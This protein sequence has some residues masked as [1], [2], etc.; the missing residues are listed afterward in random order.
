MRA[1]G[2]RRR[3]SGEGVPTPTRGP[4]RVAIRDRRSH[5][6]VRDPEEEAAAQSASQP[7]GIGALKKQAELL[8]EEVSELER[9]L[10]LELD[11]LQA[12]IREQLAPADR[13]DF[14]R[15]AEVVI[16]RWQAIL[17]LELDSLRK[18]Y[19]PFDP[20]RETMPVQGEPNGEPA[21]SAF[22]DSLTELAKR[23]NYVELG[24]TEIERAVGAI[25]PEGVAVKVDLDAFS[26]LRVFGRGR[27]H[28]RF[29]V[30]HLL[31]KREVVTGGYRRF[32]LAVALDDKPEQLF[33]RL[34]RD[35]MD[36]DLEMFLPNTKVRIG[37]GDKIKLSVLGGGGAVGG[38]VATATKVG[39]A[40]TP[41]GWIFALAGLGGIL[42]R[43][44]SQVFHHRTKYMGRLSKALYYHG[45]DNDFGALVHIAQMAA[46]QECKEVL[47]GY[48]MLAR[49]GSP[50]ASIRDLDGRAEEFLRDRFDLRANFDVADAV[51]KLESLQLI[52]RGDTG[53][54]EVLAPAQALERIRAL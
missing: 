36:T 16:A 51:R 39:A 30:R 20:T 35:V 49:P 15:F 44:T 25:S 11:V 27:F 5:Q 28:R 17:A 14:D 22:A 53:C 2:S 54:L 3:T 12:G 13:G 21:R 7:G 26:E 18:S 42:W 23:A 45:L 43:Q 38:L 46:Q 52:I 29:R 1:A 33:L 40:T 9:H 50:A 47:L 31:G 6:K 32:L 48:G 8:G 34:Y 19:R 10:P 24:R 41:Q 4:V 37:N